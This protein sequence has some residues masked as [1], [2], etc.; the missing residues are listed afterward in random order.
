MKLVTYDS[1][2]TEKEAE[3]VVDK[4]KMKE[5]FSGK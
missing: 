3:D 4:L 1:K 5:E 2:P